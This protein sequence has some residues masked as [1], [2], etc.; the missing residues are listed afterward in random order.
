M[1][2]FSLGKLFCLGKKN[3]I[4]FTDINSFEMRMRIEIKIKSHRIKIP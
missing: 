3:C 4:T 2:I 1:I